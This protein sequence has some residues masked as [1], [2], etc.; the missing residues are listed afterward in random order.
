MSH[1]DPCRAPRAPFSRPESRAVFG[2]PP[3]DLADPRAAYFSAGVAGGS[4]SGPTLRIHSEGGMFVVEGTEPE[5]DAWPQAPFRK[6]C[7]WIPPACPR[8][9]YWSLADML[10]GLGEEDE[11]L[12][13]NILPRPY[14]GMVW[15]GEEAV[16]VQLRPGTGTW[17]E[18]GSPR[19]L[20]KD[21]EA[22]LGSLKYT[23]SGDVLR[24]SSRKCR[25]EVR[26]GGEIEEAYRYSS[27]I[28]LVAGRADYYLMPA[29][30][31]ARDVDTVEVRLGSYNP[32]ASWMHPF[33]VAS[34]R[35]ADGR[36]ESWWV[37]LCGRCCVAS[38]SSEGVVAEI[39][40]GSVIL[41]PLGR[42]LVL[43]PHVGGVSLALEA[44]VRARCRPVRGG[45]RAR[46]NLPAWSLEAPG[47]FVYDAWVEEGMLY[48]VLVS[49]ER[50]RIGLV[51]VPGFIREA[52]IGDPWSGSRERLEASYDRVRV[53]LPKGT[54]LL[55]LRVSRSPLAGLR[56]VMGRGFTGS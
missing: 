40:M 34:E 22:R 44:A 29:G 12:M 27:W 3:L 14:A 20:G 17:I 47:V 18:P 8:E 50:P 42:D 26:L 41:R 43:V 33:A 11:R 25:M 31:E 36:V 55:A 30:L 16:Y 45:R 52:W 21:F 51:R 38:S 32:A 35:M 37:S 28:H 53:P 49:L 19:M 10:L 4:W 9:A 13:V 54:S 5:L 56:R 15:L 24:V 23:V 2:E 6:K 46:I 48:M 7:L 39:S 1:P